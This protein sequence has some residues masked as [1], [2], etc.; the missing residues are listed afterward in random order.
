M[1]FAK[2]LNSSARCHKN[3]YFVACFHSPEWEEAAAGWAS[4]QHAQT[5]RLV[6]H[7]DESSQTDAALTLSRNATPFFGAAWTLGCIRTFV[8]TA[9]IILH[10]NGIIVNHMWICSFVL[11]SRRRLI[12]PGGDSV[13][14]RC[15]W[16]IYSETRQPRRRER[17]ARDA[18]VS[19]MRKLSDKWVKPRTGKLD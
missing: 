7:E 2:L 4:H 5:G 16:E 6:Q 19:F 15:R 12:Q 14:Q 9:G 13:R 1:A 17:M 10:H 18:I 3:T 8:I 11:N